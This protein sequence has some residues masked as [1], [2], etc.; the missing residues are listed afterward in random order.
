MSSCTQID[1]SG[2]VAGAERRQLVYYLIQQAGIAV[3]RDWAHDLIPRA[4]PHRDIWLETI[5][6]IA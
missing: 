4:P 5:V 1:N 3:Q 6:F 2:S